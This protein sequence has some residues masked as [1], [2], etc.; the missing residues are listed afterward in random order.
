MKDADSET[1]DTRNWEAVKEQ[2]GDDEGAKLEGD[3]ENQKTEGTDSVADIR[4]FTSQR[5]FFFYIASPFN[6]MISLY[7]IKRFVSKLINWML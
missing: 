4:L 1:N 6:K 3:K 7:N 2:S 5:E